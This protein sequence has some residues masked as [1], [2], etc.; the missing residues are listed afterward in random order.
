MFDTSR[1]FQKGRAIITLSLVAVMWLA[2][3]ILKAKGF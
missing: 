2:F 1:P 3:I